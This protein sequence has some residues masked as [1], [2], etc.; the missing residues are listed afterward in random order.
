MAIARIRSTVR[1]RPA[2]AGPDAD[3]SGATGRAADGTTGPVGWRPGWSVVA[4]GD[5]GLLWLRSHH[6]AGR[7]GARS[8]GRS[9][10]A[11][12]GHPQ[13][14]R[15]AARRSPASSDRSPTTSRGGVTA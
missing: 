3:G 14:Q 15:G 9:L 6:L 2:A 4:I 13:G 7:A 11:P 12:R 10:T 1:S 5:T 8:W